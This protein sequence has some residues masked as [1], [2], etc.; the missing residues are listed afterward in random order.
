MIFYRN[1]SIYDFRLVLRMR[2]IIGAK[3]EIF[4]LHAYIFHK[5]E[6]NIVMAYW[7]SIMIKIITY[8]NTINIFNDN[9]SF[10]NKDKL[11]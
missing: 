3:C 8:Y 1:F 6:I 4:H 11:K 5:C 10:F 2:V 9:L 7:K